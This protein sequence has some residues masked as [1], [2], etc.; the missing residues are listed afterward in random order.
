M[1]PDFER[2]DERRHLAKPGLNARGPGGGIHASFPG[3]AGGCQHR[4][5][6][7]IRPPL[8]GCAPPGPRPLLP[9]LSHLASRWL[10]REPE[11][12][13][14]RAW[15]AHWQA[16]HRDPGPGVAGIRDSGAAAATGISPRPDHAT[17][18][19]RERRLDVFA[20]CHSLD[21]GQVLN[22]RP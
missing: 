8:R 17:I 2:R 4:K 20:Q 6:H 11:A 16:G 9:N 14:R 18:A 13:R 21:E 19:T 22:H 12:R 1:V 15:G 7:S 5:S 10:G 3:R